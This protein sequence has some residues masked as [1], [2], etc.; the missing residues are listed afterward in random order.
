M[1]RPVYIICS[2]SGTEDK[3]TGLVSHF[4]VLERIQISKVPSS[5][6]EETILVQ[7]LT[8]RATAVWMR[9]ED[10]S[11]DK[12]FEYQTILHIPPDNREQVV[13]EGRFFF[14]AD[15]PLYRIVV[16]GSGPPFAGPGIFR[17]ESRI[18]KVGDETWLR[19]DYPIEVEEVCSGSLEKPQSNQRAP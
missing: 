15:K 7:T 11:P 14:G 17:I 3:L 4:N 8:F 16:M 2:E 6:P 1:A 12:E 13:Q 18:R 9:S 19:Q 5:G 10:D